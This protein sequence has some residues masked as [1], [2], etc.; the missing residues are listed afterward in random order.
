MISHLEPASVSPSRTTTGESRA[1]LITLA[2]S[3]AGVVLT[4]VA[5]HREG[6][7][8]GIEPVLMVMAV[9][10]VIA[11]VRNWQMGVNTI[12]VV[13]VVEGAVRKWFFPSASELVYFYKDVLMIATLIG[14]FR[15]GQKPPLLIKRHLKSVLLLLG[16]FT[17]YLVAAAAL[18]GGPHPVIG[19]LG[20]RAYCLYVPLA[21]LLPRAFPTKDDLLNFLKWY[22]LLVLPVAVI[23]V[24]QFLDTDSRSVLNRYAI[25]EETATGPRGVATFGTAAEIYYVRITSTFSY[26]SG[27]A[28]YLPIMFALLLAI[29]SLNSRKYLRRGIRML[30]YVA[31]ASTIVLSMMTG[32]RGAVLGIVLIACVFYFHTS[33]KSAFKRVQQIAVVGV[34][35]YIALA[36]LFPQVYDAFYNRTFGTEDRMNEGWSRIASAFSLPINE[37]SYAGILGYGVGLTQNAVP[38][39]MKRLDIPGPTNPIPIGYEGESGRVMLELGIAGFVFFTLLRLALLVTVFRMCHLIREPEA[40]AL[41]YAAA[42]ALVV[43]LI[44]GGA[45]VTHT[46]NVY[47][48]FL[49][50][51]I[52]ALLN[53]EKLQMRSE[54]KNLEFRI[55]N[56][57]GELPMANGGFR[58]EE[59][60]NSQSEIRN[61]Q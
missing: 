21:F 5:T 16:I 59:I 35:L 53:A 38:T 9:V 47:Q 54:R 30:F 42:A 11:A 60:R 32:S 40:R 55:A 13:V 26:I 17:L 10:F 31:V 37:A 29:T 22:L 18:P 51:I 6:V 46:Q 27:L 14:Y 24:M 33:R 61:R 36:T 23:G 3:V 41:A 12:L 45:I 43:P 58:I 28:V 8:G 15:T 4:Y 52:M 39:L 48:W 50:G 19:L 2:S 1:A 7:V 44:A 34:I 25:N 49:I 57:D 20:L 56:G